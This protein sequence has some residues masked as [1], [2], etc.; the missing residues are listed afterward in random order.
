MAAQR[1][2]GEAFGAGREARGWGGTRL[3]GS[4]PSGEV[5]QNCSIFSNWWT[6]KMPAWSL[7]CE[8]ASLRKHVEYPA[9][10]IGSEAGA[11]QSL[12]W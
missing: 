10:L 8:P 2:C 7:P 6:R 9:Y 5:T 12:M 1:G 4:T 11:I 3:G